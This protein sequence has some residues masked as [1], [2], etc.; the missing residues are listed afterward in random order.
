MESRLGGGIREGLER[1]H[2]DTVYGTDIDY[3][4]RGRGRGC[5]F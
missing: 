2:T 4:A 3:P 1:R 5:G